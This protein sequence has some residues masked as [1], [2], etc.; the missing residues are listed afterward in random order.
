MVS[1]VDQAL[2]SAHRLYLKKGDGEVDVRQLQGDGQG[3]G[4]YQE[5]ITLR[6]AQDVTSDRAVAAGD[7]V[8]FENEV[9]THVAAHCTWATIRDLYYEHH[10]ATIALSLLTGVARI[11]LT[12]DCTLVDTHPKQWASSWSIFP[13]QRMGL[14][15]PAAGSSRR[16][17]APDWCTLCS[18][19][20]H[21]HAC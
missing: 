2:Q 15:V 7:V 19:T 21:H 18:Q 1:Q 3:T 10:F 14:Q 16:G 6:P 11:C 8:V 13:R 5:I 9:V 4:V 17:G 20:R 12:L